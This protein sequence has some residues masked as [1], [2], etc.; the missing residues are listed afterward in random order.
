SIAADDTTLPRIAAGNY[1]IDLKTTSATTLVLDN[2]GTGAAGL[3]LNDGSLST[4]GIIRLNNGGALQNI[5]TLGLS[6]AISGATSTDTINGLVIS[7]GALS[8][9]TGIT[10]TNGALNINNGGITNTGSIAGAT[11][12]NASGLV[13]SVGLTA[14][15]GLIQ[16]TGGLTITGATNINTSGAT[17]VNIGNASTP[18]TI[19]STGFK[20]T[21]AGALSGITTLNASGNITGGS[22]TA[23]NGANRSCSNSQFVNGMTVTDG[24]V[25]ATN[26]CTAPLSD[27]R[28]KQNVVS[29]DDSILSR[30]KDVN[31]V[32]FDFDCSNS[33]FDTTKSDGIYCDSQRQTGV[34]AQELATI[35]P[36]LVHQYDNGYYW[37]DY[38][39]LSIYTLKAVSEI[40]KHLN[41]NGDATLNAVTANSLTVVGDIKAGTIRADRIEGLEYNGRFESLEQRVSTI[42]QKQ[43]A[44]SSP[45]QPSAGSENVTAKDLTVGGT[46]TLN[47]PT[48]IK[49]TAKF[50]DNVTINGQTEVE[51]LTVNMNL[52]A[53]GTLEVNG[54][55]TFK[56]MARFEKDAQFDGQ[57]NVLG[58]TN[59]QGLTVNLDLIVK[60]ALEV[61]GPATF[62]E[63]VRF[64]KDAQ[65][66]GN[67]AVKGQTTFN[68]DT[69]GYATIKAG[70]TSVKVKFTKPKTAKPVI[71]LTLGD[72]KFAQYSYKNVTEEEFEIV[73]AAPSLEDLT[74]SWV[75]V[76]AE[77]PV[78][79]APVQNPAP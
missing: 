24:I 21:S 38:E 58:Y 78:A 26:G 37:A 19:T 45:S 48:T 23:G 69:A 66:D 73:L 47:G 12:I 18:L 79:T 43:T 62:K 13:T 60:G 36:E 39:G 63:M 67:V 42:E 32:N 55:A 52:I 76:S 41:S 74:F 77:Q 75:A 31:T 54:T 2:S 8:G 35:F 56:E 11:T 29:L 34:I 16:G 72:G 30:I 5:S 57:I 61:N 28:L 49:A 65:F 10:F 70:D 3:N 40:A 51:G 6:G 20:T 44:P 71:S 64:Q 14:G 25:T 9:I 22:L 4:A 15:S 1:T 53:R 50:E 17:A 33:I 68:S 7:S 27:A 46:T 59:T